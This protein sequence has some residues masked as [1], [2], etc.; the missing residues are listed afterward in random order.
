[1][2]YEVFKKSSN[3]ILA[4]TERGGH[5]CH[6]SYDKWGMPTQWFQHPIAEFLRFIK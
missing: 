3:L 4:T 6:L 5:C 1:M 2:P